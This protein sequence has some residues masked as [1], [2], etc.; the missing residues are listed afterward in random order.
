MRG[1]TAA[2]PRRGSGPTRGDALPEE[3][4]EEARR[5]LAENVSRVRAAIEDSARRAGR[6]P[7]TV[8]IVAVGKGVSAGV[9]ALATAEGLLDLG[10][11][12]VQEL[13]AKVAWPGLEGARWHFV[14]RL[15]TNKA[16]H[17][18]RRVAPHLVH[19]LDRL[20]LAQ[21]LHREAVA[22]GRRQPVLVQVN[23]ARDPRKA[24]VPP[25]ELVSFLRTLA[26]MDGLA[27]RGLMT[28]APL[29]DAGEAARP[30]FRA[31]RQLLDRVRQEGIWGIDMEHLSMGMSG[32]FEVA[33]EEG[34][35][36]VR[37]GRALFAGVED[38]EA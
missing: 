35:T 10:E 31:L 34:A 22:A 3:T 27:V 28:I 1:G 6:D 29:G 14:G 4:R 18:V 12:R 15:Q 36:L 9:L 26:T 30:W 7:R 25:E 38:G 23:V 32:D 2:R 11:N 5:R 13:L 24:G 16:R 33:V 17:L 20:E 37:V 8:T 19:S 21:V